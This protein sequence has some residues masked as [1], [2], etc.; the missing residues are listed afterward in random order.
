MSFY[1]IMKRNESCL[2]RISGKGAF[3]ILFYFSLAFDFLLEFLP[4][5]QAWKKQLSV[6]ALSF[7]L[8]LF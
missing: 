4:N 6:T 1:V 2:A 8:E 3:G 7:G 5:T